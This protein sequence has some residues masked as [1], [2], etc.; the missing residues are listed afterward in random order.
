LLPKLIQ[1]LVD[2]SVPTTNG[3][4]DSSSNHNNMLGGAFPSTLFSNVIP[5]TTLGLT[6]TTAVAAGSVFF[7]D[8]DAV[9]VE[10]QL[11]N[12]MSH[13]GIDLAGFF[14]PSLLALRVAAIAGRVCTMAADYI[15]DHTI[16]PEEL[17]FQISMLTIGCLGLMKAALIP[18][19]AAAYSARSVS[20]RDGRA[21]NM[22]FQPA[23]TSWSHYKALSVCGVLDWI[24]L[25]SGEGTPL[26]QMRCQLLQ[27]MTTLSIGCILATF[28]CT[29]MKVT[30]CILYHVLKRIHKI[31]KPVVTFSG[32]V[33]SWNCF[34]RIK[35]MASNDHPL[36]RMIPNQSLHQM[37]F[38]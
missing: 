9:T 11:L 13:L 17:L 25:Q 35:S 31:K 21:Y 8:P 1:G 20:I 5:S 24:S 30:F 18:M 34:E 19:A 38:T 16:V 23:G 28:A 15:P 33:A 12:D 37:L 36:I 6:G 10:A 14:I 22:L 26:P 3:S 2:F 4:V 29:T 32:S 27:E 7:Q